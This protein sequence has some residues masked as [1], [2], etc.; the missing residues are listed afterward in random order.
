MRSGGLPKEQAKRF[1]PSTPALAELV[2]NPATFILADIDND[3]C[4]S[5]DGTRLG[6][7]NPSLL[8]SM[9]VQLGNSYQRELVYE[10]DKPTSTGRWHN[11]HSE[12]S[13]RI[14]PTD[15]IYEEVR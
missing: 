8:R 12:W 13:M 7:S 11:D 10:G 6:A 9:H 4:H 15:P 2:H 14:R 5:S 1:D 3:G